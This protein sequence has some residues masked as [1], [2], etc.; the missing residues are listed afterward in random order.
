MDS[1]DN[2]GKRIREIQ[3]SQNLSIKKFAEKIGVPYRTIQ[4]YMLKDKSK[5]RLD[6]LRKIADTFNVNFNWLLNG[7]GDM[8]S[9]TN[10]S[11]PIA[12]IERLKKDLS[13]KNDDFYKSLSIPKERIDAAL[14]GL[15][16]LARVE[17]IELARK[18]NQPIE[19]Y[20]W[21]AGLEP[22]MFDVLL[23]KD[24]VKALLREAS[25]MSDKDLDNLMDVM[26]T[27]LKVFLDKKLKE[28]EL[29]EKKTDK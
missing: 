27:T 28:K 3:L 7:E 10:Q 13:N 29:K 22:E 11:M 26:D 16:L 21:L 12:F 24:S 14:N 5:R 2:L 1:I 17:V 25:K 15:V 9:K 8:Y 4:D 20:V 23:E 19:N 18:L 6:I